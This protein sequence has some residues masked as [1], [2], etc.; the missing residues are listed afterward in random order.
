MPGGM[1][2]VE[3]GVAAARRGATRPFAVAACLLLALAGPGCGGRKGVVRGPGPDVAPSGPRVAVA[4]ME[5][6]SNDLDASE[7]IRGAF[8]E[9]LRR[10]GWNVMPTA[11]S[12][13][14]LREALGINYG[15][16]LA[17]TTPREVCGALGVEAVFY[18]D[19]VEWNKTTTGL[20]NA[21][22]VKAAVRLYGKDGALLWEGSGRQFKQLLPQGGGRDVGAQII[23]LAVGNLLLN[24]M[25]PYGKTVGRDIAGKVPPGI[26]PGG[27]GGTK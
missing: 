7:I 25:T 2:P 12:D 20:Y 21:V 15:G 6:R 4:P 8:V 18:G 1:H 13:R 23:G 26:V 17:S 16:Q 24:P 9:E 22:S 10:R 3:G 11:E 27:A 19:V 5:N 14:L